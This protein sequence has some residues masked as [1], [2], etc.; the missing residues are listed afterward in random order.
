M[1]FRIETI[2]IK[3]IADY[4]SSDVWKNARIIPITPERAL[5]QQKNPNA[6]PGDPCLWVALSDQ[7]GEVIGFC[8]SLPGH[9]V[10]NK[11][12]MGWNSCWWVN[13]N[14]GKEAA[15]P[16]FYNFLKSWDQRVAFS[17]MTYQTRAIIDQ[18]G[19]CNTR[20]ETMV[21]SY[22]RVPVSKTI[23]RLGVPGIFLYPMIVPLALLV[24]GV[25]QIR[26]GFVSRSLDSRVRNGLNIKARNSLND[27]EIAF[28]RQ[29]QEYNFT[30]HTSEEFRWIEQN[31][32]LVPGDKENIKTG[33]KYPFSYNVKEYYQKWLVSRRNEEI[34]SISLV[35]VRDGSLKVLYLHIS[36]Q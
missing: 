15:M 11:T 23:S 7:D 14:R 5:S 36:F 29:Y 25:Q 35:S 12:R 24:N 30:R 6:K 34:T 1:S 10:R 33:S 18:L 32:W 26:I 9:D 17:D 16:L 22:L 20:E 13:P 4:A 31:P 3:D 28:I 8:G 21:Q 27:E 19:F 2:L